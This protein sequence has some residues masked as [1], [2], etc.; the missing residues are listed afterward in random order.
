MV[1]RNFTRVSKN[2]QNTSSEDSDCPCHSI[3]PKKYRSFD[4]C[5]YTGDLSLVREKNLRTLFRYGLNFRNKVAHADV[6]AAVLSAL[7]DFADKQ[8]VQ[9]EI[10][11]SAFQP[12]I[13]RV[14][15]IVSTKNFSIP[16]QH[17][18]PITVESRK[19]LKFLQKHLVI[20]STDKA[21]HNAFFVCQNLYKIYF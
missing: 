16:S 2:L 8:S 6:S 20:V 4:G 18:I 1:A 5:V 13:A 14:L 11:R 17:C 12:W 7:K 9:Q 10:N 15:Q 21:A 3:F 19:Y